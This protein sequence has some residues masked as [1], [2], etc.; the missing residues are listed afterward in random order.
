[1]WPKFLLGPVRGKIVLAKR[2]MQCFESV[3]LDLCYREVIL[4]PALPVTDW[5]SLFLGPCKTG[6]DPSS[7]TIFS[8]DCCRPTTWMLNNGS[9]PF[10][11]RHTWAY[12]SRGVAC[13]RSWYVCP[14]P[15]LP[16][17]QSKPF[18]SNNSCLLT[19]LC[20]TTAHRGGFRRMLYGEASMGRSSSLFWRRFR[21]LY[22]ILVV[23][24]EALSIIKGW[25]SI[26]RQIDEWISADIYTDICERTRRY[27]SNYD[28]WSVNFVLNFFGYSERCW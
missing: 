18:R 14:S 10:P 4:M 16:A 2:S 25:F 21:F 19:S 11:G 17:Q 24:N 5:F 12:Q 13:L 9:S 3:V 1:M 26:F 28:L 20:K 23:L 15:T 27:Y 8:F 22:R 7:E 6:S